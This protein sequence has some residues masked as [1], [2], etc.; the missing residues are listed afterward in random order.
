MINIKYHRVILTIFHLS[1]K[2]KFRVERKLDDEKYDGM[3][4]DHD[5]ITC[6]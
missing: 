6:K 3:K 4:Y 2:D 1:L 5:E